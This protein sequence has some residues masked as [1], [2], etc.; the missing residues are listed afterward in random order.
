M[1]LLLLLL[2]IKWVKNF[3]YLSSV[4]ACIVVAAI[5]AA[6]AIT[7]VVA[8]WIN[9]QSFVC[10]YGFIFLNFLQEISV[11]YCVCVYVFMGAKDLFAHM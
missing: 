11:F 1:L 4:I 5:A 6:A 7:A 8:E 2:P 3:K 9:F 10:A